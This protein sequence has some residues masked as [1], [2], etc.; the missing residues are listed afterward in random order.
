MVYGGC[1]ECG[2]V[3]TSTEELCWKCAQKNREGGREMKGDLMH[4]I[5]TGIKALEA[6]NARLR[7]LLDEVVKSSACI[8]V[9]GVGLITRIK[10]ELND[11]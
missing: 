7:K 6:K 10:K 9:H 8:D 3:F 1:I 2:A 11:G 5:A 4:A